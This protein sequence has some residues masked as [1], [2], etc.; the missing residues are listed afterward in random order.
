[1]TDVTLSPVLMLLVVLVVF[2]AMVRCDTLMDVEKSLDSFMRVTGRDQ[3]P[4]Y[5]STD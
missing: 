1:M 2:V 5:F 4:E 3:L